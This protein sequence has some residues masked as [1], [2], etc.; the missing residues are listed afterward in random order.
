MEDWW[1]VH[2]THTTAILAVR[3]SDVAALNDM[4]RARRQVAGELG[5]EIRI[6][7]KAFSVGDRVIFEKNQRVRTA[8]L[9]D[10]SRHP[11]LVRLRN[12]TFGTVAALADTGN[13]VT[14]E[15]DVASHIAEAQASTHSGVG[16]L[17]EVRTALQPIPCNTAMRKACSRS[18]SAAPTPAWSWWLQVP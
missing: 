2:R 14:R 6:G 17:C 11:E 1:S 15:G 18:G 5:T 9:A 8:D 13:A 3:R 7:A 12:G 4:A 10:T 16:I